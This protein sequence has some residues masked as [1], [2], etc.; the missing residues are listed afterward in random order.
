MA[1]KKGMRIG[2]AV[3]AQSVV[4]VVLGKKG[5]AAARVEFAP[6]EEAPDG[7]QR[8]VRAIQELKAALERAGAGGT[9]GATVHVALLPPLAD[10]RLVPFPPMRRWEAEAVLGR[11]VGRYFL[12]A[13]R[14]RL[15]G[16]RLPTGPGRSGGSGD[17][18]LENIL[19]AAA[20]LALVEILRQAIEEAGWHAASFAAGQ[21]AWAGIPREA[22]GP[23]DGSVVA[24]VAILNGTAH[25]LRLRGPDVVAV[26]QVPEGEPATLVAALGGEPGRALV[27]ASPER[28][29][30]IQ[31]ALIPMGWSVAKDPE[32]WSGAEEAAAARA[33]E[34]GLELVPPS[35]VQERTEKAGRRIRALVSAS[36]VLLL[37]AAGAQLWG[38]H[39]ELASLQARRAEIGPEVAPLIAE[40]DSLNELAARARSMRELSESLPMWT[41][42][43]V[44]LA[45]QLPEDS[46]L[47][48]FYASGDTV[49]IE[50]AGA[51]AGEAIQSLKEAGLFEEV[52]LQAPVERELQGG[53]TVVERFR[54]WA[55]LPG[56][57]GGEE[58]S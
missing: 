38:A 10:V 12:G 50:A 25:V 34:K 48:A 40:R 43:L 55:R 45:A 13:R 26:R 18:A 9:T 1:G 28:F 33:G 36:V 47:T 31:E 14:P 54:L 51:R 52:R 19:A 20:P 22:G 35:V 56:R 2:V 16:V 6:G 4:A 8:A 29:R 15:V 7:L 58:G 39:R 5:G 46:Y 3:G 24:V 42:S 57:Q 53:E 11:D 27:V 30:E 17:G 32:G 37:A 23:R 44:D 49:E 21:G 41:R